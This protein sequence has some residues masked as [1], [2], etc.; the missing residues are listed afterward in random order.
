MYL[1]D[2]QNR[3]KGKVLRAFALAAALV[4]SMPADAPGVGRVWAGW[5]R[6]EADP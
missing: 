1:P 4:I 5:I 6:G 3:T 2:P